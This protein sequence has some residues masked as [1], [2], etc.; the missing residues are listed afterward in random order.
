MT[1]STRFDPVKH[2][3]RFKNDF[4]NVLFLKPDGTPWITTSGRC[5]GMAFAALD[6]FFAGLAIPNNPVLPR[7]GT[8]LA[9]YISKRLTDSISLSGA[10]FVTLTLA[11]DH[12]TWFSL[13]LTR[14]T[15]VTESS[16]IRQTIDGGT[17]AV[18]GLVAATATDLGHIGDNH[19]V[20]VFGY[21]PDRDPMSVLIYDNNFPQR[22]VRL[23]SSPLDPH[24]HS[25]AGDNWR[26]FFVEWYSPVIPDYLR[27]GSLLRENSDSRLYVI[28]GGAKFLIPDPATFDALGF[29]W[30]DV[31][32]VGDGS[33]AYIADV[34]GDRALLKEATS[35]AVWVIVDG[36]RRYI[37]S[38]ADFEAYGFSW[39][40][41]RTI[42]EGALAP[43]PDGGVLPSAPPGP[44]VWSQLSSGTIR[45]QD[46]ADRIEYA[47]E[48]GV[49]AEDEVEFRLTLAEPVTW[50]K[51]LTVPD[52]RGSSSDII[53]EGAGASVA[54]T[55]PAGLIAIGQSLTLSKA[56]ALGRM[57]P[58]LTLGDLAPL[59]GGDR[60]TFT[61]ISD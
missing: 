7:D 45:T 58:V 22:S 23:N 56:K 55:V 28:Y 59:V 24:Y 13:G 16:K 14:W 60:V 34:P 39:T 37:A 26:G 36:R 31:R 9:D 47:I 10:K 15:K 27:E 50:K 57:T 42:P 5:G 30:A 6:Y 44:P 41:V 54:K 32:V 40:K 8:L 48:S 25:T 4:E 51:I 21:D 3:F 49:V 2:G 18:L 1:V 12:G 20:V 35:P 46:P 38:A 33:M 43:I 19:Q 17:P 52:G 11:P 53:A 29:T 61:W